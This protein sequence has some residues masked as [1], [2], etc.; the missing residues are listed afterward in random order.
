MDIG[1]VLMLGLVAL[2][3]LGI[4][5][6]TV[7]MFRLVFQGFRGIAKTMVAT[8]AGPLREL[9]LTVASDVAGGV[10]EGQWKG[11]PVKVGWRMDATFGGDL[12][13]P[14]EF[15]TTIVAYFAQPLGLGIRVLE[16]PGAPAC[17]IPGLDGHLALSEALTPHAHGL[18]THWAPHIRKVLDAPGRLQI[19]DEYVAINFPDIV[20]DKSLLSGALENVCVLHAGIR[21]VSAPGG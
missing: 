12:A 17:G 13:P 1:R 8:P 7:H 18:M 21:P 3:L 20:G 10:A 14:P 4:L 15:S 11:I 5:A 6:I 16:E 2:M 9:G 19:T